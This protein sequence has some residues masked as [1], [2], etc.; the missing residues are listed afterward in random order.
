MLLFIVIFKMNIYSPQRLD[1][2]ITECLIKNLYIY[3]FINNTM[4]VSESVIVDYI[5]VEGSVGLSEKEIFIFLFCEF[6]T[7]INIPTTGG[8]RTSPDL[9]QH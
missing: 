1:Y 4:M 8:V 3:F 6:L 5:K 2:Y 7:E 9:S